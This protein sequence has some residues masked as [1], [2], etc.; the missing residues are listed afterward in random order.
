MTSLGFPW[1]LEPSADLGSIEGSPTICTDHEHHRLC[2][3]IFHLQPVGKRGPDRLDLEALEALKHGHSKHG[4]GT[5]VLADKCWW[6]LMIQWQYWQYDMVKT[7]DWADVGR[8]HSPIWDDAKLLDPRQEN[9]AFIQILP[10]AR[11]QTA[12]PEMVIVNYC[13]M[14]RCLGHNRYNR[15]YHFP[16]EPAFVDRGLIGSDTI[17][18]CHLSWWGCRSQSCFSHSF[19]NA[20]GSLMGCWRLQ[21][22]FCFWKDLQKCHRHGAFWCILMQFGHLEYVLNQCCSSCVPLKMTRCNLRPTL[23][24]MGNTLTTHGHLHRNLFPYNFPS[25]MEGYT[26]LPLWPSFPRCGPDFGDENELV[27]HQKPRNESAPTAQHPLLS[28]YC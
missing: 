6:M 25:G 16:A 1:L 14:L 23:Q 5:S 8:Y 19:L 10:F 15:I 4:Q 11:R 27:R 21:K 2:C 28:T 26:L 22:V 18:I 9:P 12:M 7:C 17:E 13:G 3:H 24:T 20:D